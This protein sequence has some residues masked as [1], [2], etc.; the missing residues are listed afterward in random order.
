MVLHS[1]D[2][3]DTRFYPLSV[4]LDTNPLDKWLEVI[5]GVSYQKSGA[6][7]Q[8]AYESFKTL[9]IEMVIYSDSIN[10]DEST[11]GYYYDEYDDSNTVNRWCIP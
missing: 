6:E 2:G 1:I 11:V 5:R 9:F 10:D 7:K 8:W 4:P 3:N